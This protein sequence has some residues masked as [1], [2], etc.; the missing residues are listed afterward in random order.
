MINPTTTP[1]APKTP[2]ST[3]FVR[4]ARITPTARASITATPMMIAWSAAVI[5]K[6]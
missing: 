1:S 3:F 4:R 2:S 6:E 5:V